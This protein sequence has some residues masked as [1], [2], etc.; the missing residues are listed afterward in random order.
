MISK[1][2]YEDPA[3]Q[4][5]VHIVDGNVVGKSQAMAQV[6]AFRDG[7]DV[8][9][10][11]TVPFNE[12][13][14]ANV[15]DK[16]TAL[17]DGPVA[18]EY[19]T[20]GHNN[21]KVSYSWIFRPQDDVVVWI[22]SYG[23]KGSGV[24]VSAYG[25]ELET[26]EVFRKKMFEAFP[27]KTIDK[28]PDKVPFKFWSYSP[29]GASSRY[30][31]INALPWEEITPNYPKSTLEQI[32]PLFKLQPPIEAGKIILWHGQ[33]GTGK[34]SLIRSLSQAWMPWCDTAF[35]VDPERFFNVSEYMLEVCLDNMAEDYFWEDEEEETFS[36]MGDDRWRLLIVEDADEFIQSDAKDRTGQALSRL[37]NLGDGLIGT[38]LNFLTLITTNEKLDNV[39]KAVSR[40]GRCLANIHFDN[41]TYAEAEVW[42][43]TMFGTKFNPPKREDTYSL[44][45]LY[46]LTRKEEKQQIAAEKEE[47]VTGVYL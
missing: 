46:N 4:K 19:T 15:L 44:A 20:V 8:M 28:K 33:P 36:L 40:P 41:F 43:G 32:D 18:P 25:K 31:D 17:F 11:Y 13:D 1:E 30:R 5:A 7:L 35:V 38:G 37:L 23:G 9:I 21:K 45:E 2:V 3:F 12:D 16:I 10:G 24:S 39:H 26:L 14:N 27:P 22:C 29:D 47:V 34:S 6:I 42:W